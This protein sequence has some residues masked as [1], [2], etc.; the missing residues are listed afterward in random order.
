MLHRCVISCLC[1]NHPLT[2][3]VE[4]FVLQCSPIQ[5]TLQIP[6]FNEKTIFENVFK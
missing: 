5:T 6:F 3:Y 4:E 1:D 2:R